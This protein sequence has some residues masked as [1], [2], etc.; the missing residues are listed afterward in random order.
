VYAKSSTIYYLLEILL[1]VYK[2]ILDMPNHILV[3]DV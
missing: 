3:N 1:A 2:R